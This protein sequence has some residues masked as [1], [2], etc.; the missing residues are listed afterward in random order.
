MQGIHKNFTHPDIDVNAVM[1]NIGHIVLASYSEEVGVHVTV[2]PSTTYQLF[3][4]K[5]FTV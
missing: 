5:I 1:I 4:T 2:P 3:E